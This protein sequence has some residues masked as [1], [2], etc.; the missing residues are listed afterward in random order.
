MPTT[1]ELLSK[2]TGGK[3]YSVLDLSDAYLQVELD[4]E[5]SKLCV[6]CTPFGLFRY[7]RLPFGLTNAPQLFQQIVDEMLRD[8]PNVGVYLDDIIITGGDD[9]EHISILRRVLS[10]LEE[11]GFNLTE[12]KCKF[13]QTKVTYLGHTLENGWIRRPTDYRDD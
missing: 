3:K 9:K 2:L 13:M 6:F 12:E 5:S 4:K 7:R 8:V 10:I 11:K 1:D